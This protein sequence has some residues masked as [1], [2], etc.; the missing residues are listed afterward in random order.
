MRARARMTPSV[1]VSSICSCTAPSGAQP[2]AI[3]STR[4]SV[5]P[6]TSLRNA[7]RRFQDQRLLTWQASEQ[8]SEIVGRHREDRWP[9]ES[10]AASERGHVLHLAHSPTRVAAAQVGVESLVARLHRL[11]AAAIRAVE[12]QQSIGWEDAGGAR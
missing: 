4:V 7:R 12:R 2:L 6:S 3:A 8:Q 5:G 9:A 1:T 11:A 10:G